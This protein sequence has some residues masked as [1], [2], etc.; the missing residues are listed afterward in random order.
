MRW[1]NLLLGGGAAVGAAAT[2][3]ALARRAV[4]PLANP[5]GGEEGTLEWRGHE[6]AYTVRG[7]GPPVLLVHSIHAAGWSYE[8]KDNVETLARQH[9][10]YALDLLGFGRSSRPSIRYSAR[11]YLSLIS[12]FVEEVVGGP[13]A[14]V[15]SSLTAAYAIVLGARDPARF[16]AIV[17][18][19]PTGLVRLSD[20]AGAPGDVARLGIDSPVL[21][22]AFFNGLVSRNS[23]RS[24]LKLIYHDNALVTD[25]MVDAY[26]AASHQPGAKHA[27]AAFVAQQLNIDVRHAVRRLTQP[28]L[29]VWGEQARMEPIDEIRPF[30]TLHPDFETAIFDPSGDLPHSERAPEFNEIVLGFLARAEAAKS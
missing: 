28:A 29:L 23:L 21:G 4:A 18:V 19:E 8:W 11:L 3:N 2:Y 13:C 6:V 14:L 5:L 22:T 15:A 17:V 9:T 20:N 16:P 7:S 1:R 25:E 27:P 12:E 30:L 10:V 24:F 26:Y